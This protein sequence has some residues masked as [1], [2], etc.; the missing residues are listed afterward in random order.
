LETSTDLRQLQAAADRSRE[1]YENDA[2]IARYSE[3]LDLLQREVPDPALE[4]DL[5]AGRID[6]FTLTA[7]YDALKADLTAMVGIADRLDDL[8]RRV[9]VVTRKAIMGD[10][11]GWAADI[12][13]EAEELLDRARAA[14]DTVLEAECLANLGMAYLGS[15]ELGSAKA[16]LEDALSRFRALDDRHGE[17]RC[18]LTLARVVANIGQLA[19]G[20]A[21]VQRGL[22]IS[23]ALGDRAR[24]ALALNMLG[25]YGSDLAQQRGYLEQALT[26]ARA[27][28]YRDVHAR[29]LNNLALLYWNLGLY[30][31]A[32]EYAQQ[33]VSMS[34]EM[35]A[36]RLI[37]T[38][39]ETL[40][41]AHLEL[42]E[43][44]EARE[45]FAEGLAGARMISDAFTTAYYLLGLGRIA[46]N[47]GNAAAAAEH[48][49]E[50]AAK[51]RDMGSPPE[52]PL[53]LAWLGTAYL[54]M[55]DWTA[56]ND[57]TTEAMALL[58]GV[59]QGNVDTPLQD[60]WWTRYR[61]VRATPAGVPSEADGWSILERACVTLLDNI[62]SVTD[63]GLRRNYLN[64]VEV[65][66]AVMLAWALHGVDHGVS[67]VDVLTSP[68]GG[69]ASI[70]DQ[71]AR[72]LDI[73][74]RLNE[75]RDETL[76][77]FLMDELVELSGAERAFLML[78]DNAGRSEVVA[79][80]GVEGSAL[81]RLQKQAGELLETV[82]RARQPELRQDMH[83]TAID[84]SEG[85]G[86]ELE[87]RSAVALPLIAHGQIIGLLY[88]DVRAI[89]GTFTQADVDLLTVLAAQAAAALENA[90]LYQETLRTNRELEERVTARTADLQQAN[91]AMEARAAELTTI[92]RIGQAMAQHLDLDSLIEVVGDTLLETFDAQ[93]VFVA[94]H[95]QQTDLI[96]FPYDIDNGRRTPGRSLR[97]GEGI[98]S[99]IL[100]SGEP[101]LDPA[102]DPTR[103]VIGTPARSF[104]GVPIVL[105][106]QPIGVISVQNTTREYAFDEG[107]VRLLS[108]IASNVGVAIQNARLYAETRRQA[109]EMAA[110][111]EVGRDI[112]VM[113]D[114]PTLLESITERARDLLKADTSAV[115]LPDPAGQ[116]FTAVV[117]LG[118]IAR[119][120]KASTVVPGRGIIGDLAA[121]G[122]AEVVNDTVHDPRAIT[123]PGTEREQV[124]QLM[125]VP[126]LARQQV[127]GM[128]AVWRSGRLDPFTPADLTFLE[129]LSR[130]ATIA[131]ENARLFE[132]A[133]QARAI[134]EEANAAKST[135]LANMSHELRTPL[136]AII[137]YSEMLQEEAEDAGDESYLP[138]LQKIN[139]A[140]KHLLGLINAILDLSK[141]EAGKMDLYLETFELAPVIEDVA[142]VV[143]PL[144]EK[145]HN[146]L[147][148]RCDPALVT[149]HADVT[150]VR[151]SVFNLLSNAA[152]FTRQGSIAL[153]A[154]RETVDSADWVV[155]A[156]R[157]TG[158]G[159]SDEQMGRLFEEFT[160]ADA[161]TTRDYGGTGLG[162]ALSRR[163]CRMMGGDITVQSA[164][165]Q[166]STFTIHLPLDVAA[167]TEAR[168]AQAQPPA[169][170]AR[171]GA[172]SVLVI[173]DEPSV[174][175]LLT[176]TLCKEN[177]QVIT[178][179]GGEEGLRLARE[180]RP[181]VITLDVLMPGMDG[182]TVLTELK[183]DAALHDI[184][185]VMLTIVDDKTR[186]YA[187]QAADYLTKPVD[188]ERLIS[189]LRR[190]SAEKS[191]PILVVDDDQ[192]TRERLRHILEA[193]GW[194]V[195]EA[196]NGREALDYIKEEPPGVILLDLMMP[197][198][199]G[200]EVV[201]E[202]R[203]HD[204]W[205]S[206]PV[207]V[208]TAKDITAE[209]RQRLNGR[210]EK[211]IQKTGDRAATAVGEDVLAEV[212]R[213]VAASMNQKSGGE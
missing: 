27:I 149:M 93:N 114:V 5:R 153:T 119:E 208:L 125:V 113:L 144:V 8:S 100:A 164:L 2:A 140:G 38:G 59:G 165:G 3:A 124:E 190:Y 151:Q 77:D 81:E 150:K 112:S 99:Q 196:A 37:S 194:I 18:V 33:S 157:D 61:V 40:G 32:R 90:R 116:I 35:H 176:R 28:G 101:L 141:I 197:E 202:L 148:V 76:L 193:D 9:G 170:V 131:L 206:I 44:A 30:R 139:Q 21:H 7:A 41:R 200:F 15:G 58:E 181:D 195:Q 110:L 73:S 55:G 189:I 147:E 136:N 108:T 162:L 142:A 53:T 188:R 72:M 199:D 46:L 78:T 79:A 120:V 118:K 134:A 111:A 213:L 34:R 154:G 4:Y 54:E 133:R 132:D 160:Q 24:E 70:R 130:Q 177:F 128:M 192:S 26:L 19:Q 158:I 86:R 103:K 203:K 50:A 87:T 175:D 152:K 92:N 23:R 123:I 66:R 178:A 169:E 62:A 82:T 83:D 172:P 173:D 167:A 68:D 210:V 137:G 207:V 22:E 198:V 74:L 20:H 60:I 184:P 107:D 89:F 75:R 212:R 80:R 121:R 105:G 159:M 14:H 6:C 209:E 143:R 117:A 11:L 52:L 45:A 122:A 183:A 1:L 155:V 25:G 204:E 115:Y 42:G 126:L 145:N 104:L 201:G 29:A 94:L 65:N 187:L 71:L 36:E 56:A 43:Y 39:L 129:G 69:R 205:R 97:F 174:R 106:D 185:V 102:M 180:I 64:K 85:S 31:R 135:F 191:A 48:I 98:S 171:N 168:M 91:A 47:Q 67:P 12:R 179:P 57:A 156:V 182:W 138:D 13:D 10:P 109:G 63:A 127:I 161:S 84:R 211:V 49:R 163:L 51:F 186:G 88:A 95:D 96:H 146:T 166:G 16:S 17:M